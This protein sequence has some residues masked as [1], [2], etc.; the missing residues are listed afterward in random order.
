VFGAASATKKKVEGLWGGCKRLQSAGLYFDSGVVVI[1]RL[2]RCNEVYNAGA[3]RAA[4]CSRRDAKNF[5]VPLQILRNY[6]TASPVQL[7]TRRFCAE[8]GKPFDPYVYWYYF[9][10]AV[11]KRESNALEAV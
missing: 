5:L 8:L 7:P 3:S 2:S 6:D 10:V 9:A 11:A 1:W 4:R